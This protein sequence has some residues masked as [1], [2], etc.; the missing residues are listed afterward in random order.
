MIKINE[1]IVCGSCHGTRNIPLIGTLSFRGAER[2]CPYCGMSTGMFGNYQEI[3]ITPTL[4]QMLIV[5]TAHTRE[6]LDGVGSQT[7]VG[8]LINGK[9][10]NRED[11][12]PELV[13]ELKA[14]VDKGW[15][16]KQNWKKLNDVE[17][18][19]RYH[20]DLFSRA[21]RD[22]EKH[23]EYMK[24]DILEYSE[25]QSKMI[26]A[27]WFRALVRDTVEIHADMLMIEEMIPKMRARRS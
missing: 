6:Y 27:T 7:C 26:D 14:K 18:M 13:A 23:L 8:R 5:Y 11:F 9:S 2:W 12:P 17:V 1:M 22:A 25:G 24:E 19:V 20:F 16:L 21:T 3:R 15:K 10:V 4:Q